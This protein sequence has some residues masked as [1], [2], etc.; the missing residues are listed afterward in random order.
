MESLAATYDNTA[1]LMD[2]IHQD[3]SAFIDENGIISDAAL[4]R[5]ESLPETSERA[6]QALMDLKTAQEEAELKPGDEAAE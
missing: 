2:A 5:L 1:D 3:D 4:S 6:S